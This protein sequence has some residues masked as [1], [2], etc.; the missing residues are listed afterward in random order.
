MVLVKICGLMRPEDIFAVNQVD[1]DFAGFVFAPS[2]HQV[3]LEK[4]LALKELLKPEIKT[5]GVFVN[6]SVDEMLA[7]YHAGAID[8]AQLHGKSTPTEISQLKQAG[9][10][11]I[12]VFER[13]TV[14]TTSPA[15][16]L[17]VDSGKGSGQLLDLTRIPHLNRSLILAGGLTPQN[18]SRAIQIVRPDIVDV[19]SGVETNGHKDA[20]KINQF[21]KNAKEEVYYENI[22]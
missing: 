11:V 2:R 1:A 9:L 17:M 14:D 3:S 19:S 4:A 16:Y 13:Q 10:G 18:V 15:D 8:I 5:V 6:E 12:Q 20:Q 7:I 22:K 21:V